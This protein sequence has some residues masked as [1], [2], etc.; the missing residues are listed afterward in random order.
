MYQWLMRW[1][2]IDNLY[3]KNRW[4][5]MNR[6]DM[7]VWLKNKLCV[8]QNFFSKKESYCI[9]K[10]NILVF[11]TEYNFENPT[12]NLCVTRTYICPTVW[13]WMDQISANIILIIHTQKCFVCKYQTIS[14]RSGMECTVP[15]GTS[16]FY[17]NIAN[18]PFSWK[19][20]FLFIIIWGYRSVRVLE[21]Y[22]C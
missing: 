2:K 5:I 1:V 19:R 16:K 3:F 15:F 12:M 22:Q 14:N 13:R 20:T 4:S 11:I 8:D 9:F 18:G 7:F 21:P 6:S 10:I 17:R